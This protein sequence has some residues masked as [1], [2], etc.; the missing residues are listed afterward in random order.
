MFFFQ[1]NLIHIPYKQLTSNPLELSMT[2]EEVVL[3]TPDQASLHAWYIPHPEA[4][5]TFW[6]FSGNAGN[7]SYMLDT[8]R[9]IHD[10]GYSV[11]IYDYRTYGPSTGRLT[12]WNMYQDTAVV[13]NYLTEVKHTPPEHIILHGRSLGTAMATWVATQTSP[14]AVILESGFTSMTEMAQ[15]LYGWLPIRLLLQWNYDNLGRIRNI[16]TPILIIHSP[17]DEIVPFSY[18]QRLYDAAVSKKQFLKISG[19][20]L[21]GYMENRDKYASGIKNFISNIN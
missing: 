20:H 21:E 6:I 14:A 17:D 2:F 11:F 8:I 1:K 16:S 19:N 9:L 5:Y 3:T 10:L 13:W 15:N 7:K 4:Q 12:E 18:A